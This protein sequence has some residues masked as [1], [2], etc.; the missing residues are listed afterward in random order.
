MFFVGVAARE[1]AG[2]EDGTATRILDGALDEVAAGGFKSVSIEGVARRAGVNRVTIYR[3]FRD[4]DGLIAA[5]AAREGHRMSAALL[6][7]VHGIED[8]AERLVEGFLVALRYA[9]NHPL[10]MR[11]ALVEP[12]AVIAAALADDAALLRI[13]REFLA[14]V[15]RDAHRARGTTH[16]DADQAGETLARLF[17]TFVLL[18]GGLLDS[19]NEELMRDYAQR[20]LVPMLAG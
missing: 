12:E 4:R 8:P 2:E 6:L 16:I 20:T 10:V 15:I 3:R 9:R 18:P 5:L 1:P 11:A 17:A 14:E 19:R 13:G 7:A